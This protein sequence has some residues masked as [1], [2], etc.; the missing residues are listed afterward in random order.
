MENIFILFYTN[1]ENI[2]HL[3]EEIKLRYPFLRPSFSYQNLLSFKSDKN[4]KLDSIFQ[5]NPVFARRVSLFIEKTTSYEVLPTDHF[6]DFENHPTGK[7]ATEVGQKVRTIYKIKENYWITEHIHSNKLSPFP[8]SDPC[9]IQ[10]EEAPSR[11]YLKIAEATMRTGESL[12]N[13]TVLELGSSPGGASYF[14][15]T[16]GAKV[17]GVDPAEMDSSVLESPLF[18]HIHKSVQTVNKRDIRLGKG[19]SIIAN[20]MNLPFEQSLNETLRMAE[21]IGDDLE[22]V[23][24][25]IK[26]PKP[27]MVKFIKGH[28]DKARKAGF[29]KVQGMSLVSHRNEYLLLMRR[30]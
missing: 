2:K 13:K 30:K 17:Y 3:K 12:K 21:M 29:K 15:T 8:V 9:L 4:F 14:L 20:D 23:Y 16:E 5:I 18:T 22:T 26:L 25:T 6:V 28:I 10:P 24:L 7:P 19:I 11:A 27:F 1:S